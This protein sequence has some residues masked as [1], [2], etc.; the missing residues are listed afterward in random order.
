MDTDR[1]GPQLELLASYAFRER[2]GVHDAIK[3]GE[4]LVGQCA[5]EKERILL[6]NVP[7]RLHRRSA[8][9]WARPRR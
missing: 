5:L 7:P 1:R 2:E 8:P 6:T 4:G 3:L 9:A